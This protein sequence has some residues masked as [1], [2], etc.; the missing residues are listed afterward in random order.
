M[1]Y[2][3]ATICARFVVLTAGSFDT[4][5]PYKRSP[6]PVQI[7]PVLTVSPTHA[8]PTKRIAMTTCGT[9][10][11]TSVEHSTNT[12]KRI[13]FRVNGHRRDRVEAPF[14]RRRNSAVSSRVCRAAGYPL[15]E[16]SDKG[17]FA[18]VTL[19]IGSEVFVL[20]LPVVESWDF[21]LVIGRDLYENFLP[22]LKRHLGASLAARMTNLNDPYST[23]PLPTESAE[24]SFS[25]ASTPDPDRP[26][27]YRE[28]VGDYD[29]M[30]DDTEPYIPAMDQDD[31]PEQDDDEA[32]EPEYEEVLESDPEDE[33]IL[34][35]ETEDEEAAE[36]EPDSTEG[37][38]FEI[39]VPPANPEPLR[40]RQPGNRRP[41]Q[42]AFVV[43]KPLQN[44]RL[45]PRFCPTCGRY[46]FNRNAIDE[47]SFPPA[48]S[49]RRDVPPRACR[50]C[51]LLEI[52][53]RYQV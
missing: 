14:T 40:R 6:G 29:A 36:L 26:P 53:R 18:S 24:D 47:D 52:P 10:F 9:L 17:R 48:S 22:T 15:V 34:D 32:A 33:E 20:W 42:P 30:S 51:G 46:R 21:V 44:R 27:T 1:S 28:A 25:R 2:Q 16:D 49:R 7:T 37:P 8:T 19:C 35:V 5:T 41:A 4:R 45:R 43:A 23:R 31:D 39:E 12:L 13:F 11:A 3:S 50:D 38:Q